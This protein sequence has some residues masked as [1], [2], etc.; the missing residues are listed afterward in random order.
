MKLT[1][2]IPNSILLAYPKGNVYQWYGEN[3]ALYLAAIG[4]KGHTGLDIA[5]FDGDKVVAAHDGTIVKTYYS[6][7]GYGNHIRILSD[8]QPDGTYIETI[9]GH[10]DDDMEVMEVIEGQK[11]KA[12]DLIGYESNTGFVIS[13]GSPYWGNAPAGKGV[14]LHFG[15]RILKDADDTSNTSYLGKNYIILNYENG[16]FGYI[17]PIGYMNSTSYQNLLMEHIIID[18]N[19]FLLYSDLKLA[20]EIGDPVELK[21]LQLNGLGGLPTTKNEDYIKDYTV[22]PLI[23]RDR[24]KDLF[25]LK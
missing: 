13:G 3:V 8:I 18:N 7:Q 22:Y 17:D 16:L 11:V 14:H 2:P 10:L 25:G 12:G 6:P 20:L 19:Q 5:T 15:L 9:Y 4:A 21:K 1:N 23:Q 24:L